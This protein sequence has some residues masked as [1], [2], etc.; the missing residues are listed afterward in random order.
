MVALPVGSPHEICHQNA[1]VAFIVGKLV[2]FTLAL[3]ARIAH[4]PDG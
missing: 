2:D 3:F 1:L 4:F